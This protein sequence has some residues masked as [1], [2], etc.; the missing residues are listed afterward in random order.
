MISVPYPLINK[1]P[2]LTLILV[3]L[4]YWQITFIAILFNF[5]PGKCMINAE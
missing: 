2:V 1:L 5:K 3:L 4:F